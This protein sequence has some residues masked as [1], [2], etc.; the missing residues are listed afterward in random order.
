MRSLAP[1][2]SL[3]TLGCF[4][5]TAQ[6]AQQRKAQDKDADKKQAVAAAAAKKDKARNE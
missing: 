2:I 3:L 6:T 4:I 1:F 5:S